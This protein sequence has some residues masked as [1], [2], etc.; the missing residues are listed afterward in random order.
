MLAIFQQ[1]MDTIL[2]NLDFMVAYLD[3]IFMNSQNV[4]QHK[5]YVL[6]S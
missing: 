1:V 3:D 5:K 4:E 2:S 6:K